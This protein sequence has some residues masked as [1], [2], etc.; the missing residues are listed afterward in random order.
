MPIDKKPSSK[1]KSTTAPGRGLKQTA[2]IYSKKTA[3]LEEAITQMNAGKYGRSSSA[4]KELL[5]LDP[6]NMEARRLFATLHL[7]LGSLIPARQAFDSLID[8]AFSR[9]DYWLA[10]S[11]L[12]EYL[13]AGPRC[14]PYLEK[15]GLIHQDKGEPNE[16]VEHYA[17]A[18][19]IL[20]EDPDPDNP[21]HAS[22]LYDKIKDLAPGSFV[23]TRVAGYFDARTGALIARQSGDTESQSS[24]AEDSHGLSADSEP[25]AAI[26]A[27]GKTE[28]T[29]QAEEATVP[30]DVVDTPSDAIEFVQPIEEVVDE[31]AVS[32]P[33]TGATDTVYA[34]S[35]PAVTMSDG[36]SD[37]TLQQGEVQE[38][39]PQEFQQETVDQSVPD[40]MPWTEAQETASD[41]AD[42]ATTE[43]PDAMLL[44]PA[45]EEAPPDLSPDAAKGGTFSWDSVFK[46]VWSTTGES[47]SAQNQPMMETSSAGAPPLAEPSIAEAP[48]AGA[49][50]PW[51]QVQDSTIRISPKS[52][53]ES[54]VEPSN[55]Q[56]ISSVGS[57]ETIAWSDQQPVA[58][59]SSPSSLIQPVHE[60]AETTEFSFS[61]PPLGQSTFE[62]ESASAGAPPFLSPAVFSGETDEAPRQPFTFAFSGET[63][64][65]AE[66]APSA[67][68]WDSTSQ[69]S[70][71]GTTPPPAQY[72][73]FSLS[74]N[75]GAVESPPESFTSGLEHGAG[76]KEDAA[77]GNIFGLAPPMPDHAREQPQQEEWNR[78][79]FIEAKA[80]VFEPPSKSEDAWN[81]PGSSIR[82]VEDPPVPP[83]V[84]T[85]QKGSLWRGQKGNAAASPVAAAVDALF[86][87]VS[88]RDVETESRE[89][90]KPSRPRRKSPGILSRIGAA[91][92]SF[93]GSCFST[94]R[95]IVMSLIALVVLSCALAAVGIGAIALT[96]VVMEESPSPAYQSLTGSPV[97]TM[98]DANRNGYVFLMGFDAPSGQSPFQVGYGQSPDDAAAEKML[99]CLGGSG[100][101]SQA[102]SANASEKIL[103][104]WFRGLD[105]VGQFAANQGM[106]TRWV[107]QGE[108][109]LNRYRRWQKLPF[110][111]WGYGQAV[112]PPCDAINFAHRLYVA[113]GFA[114]QT[115]VGIDRLEADIEVWRV[116][117]A[118]AKTISVKVQAIQAL[119]D[120][121]AVASGVL[122]RPDFDNKYVDRLSR[123]V[124]PLSQEEL[125]IR[126]PMQ[127]ELVWASKTLG[128]Q[129]KAEKHEGQPLHAAVA[130]A[131]PLPSQRRLNS[132]A[133]YYEASNKA[134]EE[135]QHGT[136]PKLGGFI[137]SPA[138]TV[139]DYF[140]NPIENVIGIDPL[141]KWD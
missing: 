37:F 45:P 68:A 38:E 104:G 134:S 86:E 43:S 121:V 58:E 125:S 100:D 25:M 114:Q 137:K 7:R 57:P 112:A 55:E 91:L 117:L 56:T 35:E 89:R 24:I 28:E 130:S 109:T 63:P 17:K 94:T 8:E 110:E 93:I 118:Q 95:A 101:G 27:W 111:D 53:E 14:V 11:L 113:E 139:M 1:T 131:L 88:D 5:A 129:I 36:S 33:M 51:D 61:Q 136:L 126:W 41:M 69:S 141:P 54:P 21:N 103:S 65:P 106:I 116:V 31:V 49:P 48:S 76:P 60:A 82:F 127:S 71:I 84:E 19:D 3:L 32:D 85:A 72:E 50:M 46:N 140:T 42:Q 133:A 92:S 4:L 73:S 66:D 62:T 135:G 83:A 102:V 52:P 20:V 23:A 98:S 2:A 119:R 99:A 12:R 77:P 22:Q 34:E 107:A 47:G 9:Q 97:Q 10:E 64:K 18:I 15:L 120:D 123:M 67:P 105:P 29:F 16:A 78:P 79:S 30:S 74:M 124:R 59:S 80:P 122:A 108:T 70:T 75:G 39:F 6:H 90:T 40:S 96:W 87:P 128:A 81:Q 13:A 132:Y 138:A 44:A 115:D 26:G